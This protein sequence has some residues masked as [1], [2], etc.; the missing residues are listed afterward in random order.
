MDVNLIQT[1]TQIDF[2]LLMPRLE[3]N[4]GLDDGFHLRRFKVL[5]HRPI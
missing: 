1:I 2:K 5:R 3:L 4:R